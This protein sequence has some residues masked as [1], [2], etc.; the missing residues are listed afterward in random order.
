MVKLIELTER[1]K[2]NYLELPKNLQILFSEKLKLFRANPLHPSFKTHKYKM[3]GKQI[4]WEAY[5]NKKYRFTF[6][7]TANSYIFR[8]IG[9]HDIIDNGKV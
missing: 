1:F 2:Q 4:I 5:I 3:K 6:E 7:I 8:N 9:P